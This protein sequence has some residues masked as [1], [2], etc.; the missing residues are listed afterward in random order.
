MPVVLTNRIVASLT[1]KDRPYEVRDTK[2]RGLVLRVQPSGYKAWILQWDHKKRRTLGPLGHLTLDQA[3]TMA[4]HLMA[5][6]IQ[7]GVPSLAKPK[8]RSVTLETFLDDHYG[9]W[10][11]SEL[12]SAASII[13][14]LR[15]AFA[16]LLG[17]NLAD[18][19]TA[20]MEAWWR[21]RLGTE[22]SRTGTQVQRATAGREFAGLRAAL[23]KAVEWKLL[24]Q[25]PLK[26]MKLKATEARKVVRHLSPD[27]EARLRAALKRR[28]GYMIAARESGN[29]WR[30]E[31]DQELLPA[32]PKDGY[33]DHLTPVVLLAMN[34]GLRKGELLSLL[35]E[36]VDLERRVLTVRRPPIFE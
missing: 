30:K 17:V 35:W 10:A 7:Q 5:E 2:V 4:S 19:D 31:R 34:T 33:G 15:T 28:D 8:L 11:L 25:N 3:R 22:S 14:R 23:S 21:T 26:A 13:P 32:L 1:P 12:K 9:P 20:R 36:D 24:E 29:R 18:I 6:V 16:D 27:E